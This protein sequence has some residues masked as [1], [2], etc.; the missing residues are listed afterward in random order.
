VGCRTASEQFA[1]R[2]AERGLDAETVTGAG[3]EHLVLSRSRPPG[4][5]LHVYLDGDGTPSIEGYPAVD[6]TPR[7]PLVLDLMTLDTTPAVYIGRPCYH[8]LSGATCSSTLWTSGRYS[9]PVV[10]SMAAAVGRV[11]AANGAARIV[12]IGYSGGGVLAVLLAT[13]VP[14]TVG[15]VTIA[16][17]LDTDAWRD[18]HRTPHL[19]GSLNPAREP[20]PS[21]P[22][23]HYT[24]GRDAIVPVSITRQGATAGAEVIVVADYDHRCCWVT[25]WPTVL[26][27]LERDISP[28]RPAK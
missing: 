27:A 6:P 8:G 20:A 16:A 2:A 19:R 15:V 25:L 5:L 22:Q 11:V 4:P 23:R 28:Q 7:N 9:E 12:L 14:Q 18:V 3:F 13:R 24:G 26:A 21:V 10:A 1:Q 17:N